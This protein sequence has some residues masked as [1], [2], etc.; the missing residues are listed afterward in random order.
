MHITSIHTQWREKKGFVLERKCDENYY[1]F[2]HFLS[3]AVI[4]DGLVAKE[5]GCIFS[6]LTLTDIL[7]PRIEY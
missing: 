5:G 3:D 2:I 7:N 4:N 1:I 6:S